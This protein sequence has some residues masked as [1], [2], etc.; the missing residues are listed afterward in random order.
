MVYIYIYN[1]YRYPVLPDG[2]TD[3]VCKGEEEEDG[4]EGQEEEEEWGTK[5]TL[6]D[7]QQPMLVLPLYSL[8]SAERQAEVRALLL[9]LCQYCTLCVCVQVFKP[10]PVG[11][12]LCVVATNIAETSITIPNIRY[13][14]DSGKV[15]HDIGMRCS[16]SAC[17]VSVAVYMVC[18]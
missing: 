2:G 10:V 1:I 3:S 7:Q 18:R 6:H 13:V 4:E 12:R 17:L 9:V 5:V 8:M 11:V 16:H 14:V 15:C